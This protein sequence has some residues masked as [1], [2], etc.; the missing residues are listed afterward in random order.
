MRR[1]GVDRTRPARPDSPLS[2]VGYSFRIRG[3]KSRWANQ[4]RVYWVACHVEQCASPHIFHGYFYRRSVWLIRL[5]SGCPDHGHRA[6][7]TL[8]S[9]KPPTLDTCTRGTC[10]ATRQGKDDR[11][12]S[13]V[14]IGLKTPPTAAS[15]AARVPLW[16]CRFAHRSTLLFSPSPAAG[17]PAQRLLPRYTWAAF[18]SASASASASYSSVSG[19]GAGDGSGPVQLAYDLHK[20]A[21]PVSDDKT[22]P[23]L[24]LHGL[25]GSKKNNRSISK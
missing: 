4:R 6:A 19:G 10:E 1:W 17:R 14:P 8:D 21:K 20:P 12:I 23:I 15:M 2:A 13:Y 16:G 3:Q 9:T 24:F 7:W 18:A 22:R 11:A 25:F 5:P